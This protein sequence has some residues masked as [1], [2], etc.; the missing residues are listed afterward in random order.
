MI[1][2]VS[3]MDR[4]LIASK[5]Y[6]YFFSFSFPHSLTVFMWPLATDCSLSGMLKK[7]LWSSWWTIVTM[8][9][10]FSCGSSKQGKALRA[11]VGSKCVVASRLQK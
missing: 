11:Y 6:S 8:N 4:L 7:T 10:A 5:I 2:L 1:S 9:S 3:K